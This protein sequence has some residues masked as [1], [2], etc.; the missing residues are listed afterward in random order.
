MKKLI[1]QLNELEQ[2][3]LYAQNRLIQLSLFGGTSSFTKSKFSKELRTSV[4]F[5]MQSTDPI[6]QKVGFLYQDLYQKRFNKLKKRHNFL[7][8]TLS[9]FRK[10]SSVFYRNLDL[11]DAL[12]N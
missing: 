10:L 3:L 6:M 11:F 4:N 8:Q 9:S 12:D 1:D 2:H 7:D 5:L